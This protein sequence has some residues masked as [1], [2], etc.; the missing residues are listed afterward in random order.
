MTTHAQAPL[1]TIWDSVTATMRQKAIA[2]MNYIRRFYTT[3][4]SKVVD[5][6]DASILAIRQIN[7]FDDAINAIDQV[8]IF[9]EELMHMSTVAQPVH[10]TDQQLI[11]A[12]FFSKIQSAQ[13]SVQLIYYTT[14]CRWGYG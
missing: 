12:S 2:T 3:F 8:S 11:N 14:L 1:R 6:I 4:N 13:P 5:E 7:N 10:K 9:Q